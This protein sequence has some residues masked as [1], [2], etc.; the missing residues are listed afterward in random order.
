MRRSIPPTSR[1]IPLVAGLFL[2]PAVAQG[3]VWTAT[4]AWSEDWE[5]RYA[6]WIAAEVHEGLL[7]PIGLPVDCADL[8]YVVRAI[9][10]REHHLPF[11]ATRR[12]GGP[13]LGH[14]TDRWDH[15]P[16]AGPWQQDR[17]LR[18]FL[19]EVC[20][21][22]S[23]RTLPADT[24]PVA[25]TPWTVQPGLMVYENLVGRH[26]VLV[27]EVAPERFL[28]V[29]FFESSVPPT[30]RFKKAAALSIMIYNPAHVAWE[31][32][33]VVRWRWPIRRGVTWTL[34]ANENMPHFST[35]QYG[36]DFDHRGDL[37][38]LLQQT[39]RGATEG[40]LVDREQLLGELHETLLREIEFRVRVVREGEAAR[41]CRDCSEREQ[42]DYLYGTESR[43]MR[44]GRLMLSIWRSLELHDLPRDQFVARLERTRLA[45]S[46]DLPP[47]SLA[48]LF[49]AADR[50]LLS[51]S[52]F[53]PIPTRWG[54]EW[55]AG[56]GCWRLRDPHAGGPQP[57]AEVAT[58]S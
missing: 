49:E 36:A 8:L 2:L 13:A 56:A 46:P 3:E 20:R 58:T 28:P 37:E 18:A 25:I 34:D 54:L 43:D 47:V 55:D 27:A 24:Y 6:A 42:L 40:G 4:H 17:R 41:R 53:D 9:F 29:V 22:V 32:S 26:A 1:W 14:W 23:T 21:N 12:D 38:A 11:R 10:A 50:L 51:S 45:I 44:L 48:T 52:A 15:L 30:V 7:E 5:T 35:E 33:G 19:A 31:H 39:A 57:S 16:Q